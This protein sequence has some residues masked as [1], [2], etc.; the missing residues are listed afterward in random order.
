[1]AA[2]GAV[3]RDHDWRAMTR[4]RT[5]QGAIVAATGAIARWKSR[6]GAPWNGREDHWAIHRCNH[7]SHRR[8]AMICRFVAVSWRFVVGPWRLVVDRW[9]ISGRSIVDAWWLVVES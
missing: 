4:S 8:L 5:P 1:M 2:I 7:G 9:S 3:Q 6:L